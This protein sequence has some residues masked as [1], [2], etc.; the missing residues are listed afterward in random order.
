MFIDEID[1]LFNRPSV[2]G[3]MLELLKM[4]KYPNSNLILMGASN[5]ID[6]IVQ[7]N[8]EY[9]VSNEIKNIVFQ[10]YTYD[11]I[12]S[13]LKDRIY[14]TQGLED[15]GK[16][17]EEMAIRFCAKKIYAL[18]GGDIRYVLE[19]VKKVYIQA[20]QSLDKEGRRELRDVP[21]EEED[22]KDTL[23]LQSTN[24]LPKI[25]LQD[26]MKVLF[27]VIICVY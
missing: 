20:S 1:N 3:E 6:L 26:M 8:Q 14:K 11:E 17:F 4:P 19:V 24:S 15:K 2:A 7:L 18:K 25:T 27:S 16:V 23:D 12:F 13:I 5:T 10:P 21:A 22:T 9:K